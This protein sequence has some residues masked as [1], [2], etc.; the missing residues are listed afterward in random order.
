LGGFILEIDDAR[1]LGGTAELTDISGTRFLQ[2]NI[3]NSRTVFNIS[4]HE[5]GVYLFR[6]SG[7]GMNRE[8]KVILQK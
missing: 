1:W 3:N 6:F 4:G 2:K 8:I 5:N 7:R